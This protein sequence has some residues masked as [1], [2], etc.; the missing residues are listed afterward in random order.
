MMFSPDFWQEYYINDVLTWCITLGGHM[1]YR[2]SDF[3]DANFDGLVIV[4]LNLHNL[5]IPEE[6]GI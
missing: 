2:C 1:L 3:G 4:I 6:L 5:S